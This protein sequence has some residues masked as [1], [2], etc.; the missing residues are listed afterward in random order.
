MRCTSKYLHSS[1]LEI[2]NYNGVSIFLQL[3]N[4]FSKE[5]LHEDEEIRYIIAGS[6]YFDVRDK[7]DHWIRLAVGKNDVIILPAGIYHKFMPDR[8]VMQSFSSQLL[9]QFLN[10]STNVLTM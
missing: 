2:S 8:N 3:T 4:K 5:H 10:A 7:D 1:I 9:D 6:G